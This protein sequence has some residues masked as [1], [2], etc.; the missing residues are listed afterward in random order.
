[1]TPFLPPPVQNIP[2]FPSPSSSLL[3]GFVQKMLPAQIK[4]NIAQKVNGEEK[5]NVV[6]KSLLFQ[7]FMQKIA[8]KLS[9]HD[10]VILMVEKVKERHSVGHGCND[11]QT[12]VK[13]YQRQSQEICHLVCQT[14]QLQMF[15]CFY[16][17]KRMIHPVILQKWVFYRCISVED[18]FHVNILTLMLLKW[19]SSN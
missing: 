16:G 1:M 11:L 13:T 7:K 10:H 15:E 14:F 8:S 19:L 9:F 4:T 6:K 18:I 3:Q 17:E 2:S 12:W 5:Q